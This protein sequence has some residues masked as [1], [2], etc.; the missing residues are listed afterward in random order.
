MPPDRSRRVTRFAFTSQMAHA[1][2]SPTNDDMY[3]GYGRVRQCA[4]L[5][6]YM[7][8]STFA[9]A[10][11]GS[12]DAF[13]E[14]LQRRGFMLLP[15][16]GDERELAARALAMGLNWL[17]GLLLQGI[18]AWGLHTLLLLSAGGRPA[19]ARC[20][21]SAGRGLARGARTASSS[22]ARFYLPRPRMSNANSITNFTTRRTF[23]HE[24]RAVRADR[25]AAI[26][27]SA[28]G[29]RTRFAGYGGA[30]VAPHFEFSSSLA[31]R[32]AVLEDLRV[33]ARTNF[34]RGLEA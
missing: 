11:H 22:R 2:F 9:T 19:A 14:R 24:K 10:R 3:Y 7:R 26:A 13:T 25:G 31:D 1:R 32:A 6:Q 17:A 5:R 30:L 8:P 20:L 15:W 18:G 16:Q 34:A 28:R 29:P 21:R 23:E 33:S 12:M 4:P 27:P